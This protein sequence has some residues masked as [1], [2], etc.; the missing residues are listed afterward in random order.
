MERFFPG[1]EGVGFIDWPFAGHVLIQ[2][3]VFSWHQTPCLWLVK[4]KSC[5]F[6]YLQETAAQ[7]SGWEGN[8]PRGELPA[9]IPAGE[10]PLPESRVPD[11]LPAAR[12]G[13]WCAG[14]KKLKL[15]Q[16]NNIECNPCRVI[17]CNLVDNLLS[18]ILQSLYNLLSIILETLYYRDSN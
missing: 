1:G 6:M 2:N 4:K 18:I 14:A 7:E 12:T 9:K 8:G 5:V 16:V 3:I 13:N 11:L 17:I 10:R 15:F